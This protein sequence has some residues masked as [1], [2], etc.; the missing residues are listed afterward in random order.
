MSFFQKS[1]IFITL[2]IA[3]SLLMFLV[4]IFGVVLQDFYGARSFFYFGLLILL[5][6]LFIA[7]SSFNRPLSHSSRS[8]LLVATTSFVTLPIIFTLPLL[9]LL[10]ELDH[11]TL[12]FEMVSAFTTTGLTGIH[13]IAGISDTI[14]FWQVL[15]GWFGGLLIWTFYFAIF[16]SLDINNIFKITEKEIEKINFESKKI[17]HTEIFLNSF[18][19]IS[20]PYSI[21]TL[22]LWGILKVTG[23]T[24]F[25]ALTYSMSTMST[26]GI[27][28]NG[29]ML[30][31]NSFIG[32]LMIFLFFFFSL[33][34]TS[35][36]EYKTP[37]LSRKIFSYTELKIAFM[38]VIFSSVI[39]FL[40]QIQSNYLNLDIFSHM[41]RN[42]FTCLSFLTTT[43]WYLEP[44]LYPDINGFAILITGLVLIG[45]GVGTTAG[46]LKLL[47][48]TIIQRHL[49]SEFGKM[50]FPSVIRTSE[51][52]MTLNGSAILKVWV[53]FS[54][55]IF[56]II[57]SF[58]LL[59]FF[60]LPTMNA[61]FLSI[62]AFSNTGPLYEVIS[63]PSSLYS[64]LTT[65]IKYIL[66]L[67]MVLGRIEILVLFSLFN[68]EL[69]RK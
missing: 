66:I 30:S 13:N 41:M 24:T 37:R 32:L 49:R 3:T 21:L 35:L 46:G 39:L 65:P 56:C 28:P 47:R 10:P 29:G 68:I 7:F 11:H 67:S 55:F 59:S 44:N 20:V 12:Y 42:I 58:C 23:E 36:F 53:F 52:R 45:G 15:V 51:S 22:I 18:S 4:A 64:A 25:L 33:R 16:K 14:L 40:M 34:S 57:L 43:G 1:P 8:Q 69:W 63:Q 17:H 2:L 62:S 50:V 27:S 31:A 6:S 54:A 5:I 48:F 60:G 38:L 61:I 26:S 19:S 9:S